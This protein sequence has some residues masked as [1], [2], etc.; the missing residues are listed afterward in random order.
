MLFFFC[1]LAEYSYYHPYAPRLGSWYAQKPPPYSGRSSFFEPIILSSCMLPPRA[2]K[3]V[4]GVVT[5]SLII[6]IHW[7][8]W[9]WNR[10]TFTTPGLLATYSHI[11]IRRLNPIITYWE[12][13]LYAYI[14][15]CLKIRFWWGLSCNTCN[16]FCFRI[17]KYAQ[18]IKIYLAGNLAYKKIYNINFRELI[19]HF[20]NSAYLRWS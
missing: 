6:Q 1:M 2:S 19:E 10:N 5:I 11:H 9:L 8:F 18:L 16:T 7:N 17:F 12:K 14:T 4:H 20:L 15:E 13:W 3:W